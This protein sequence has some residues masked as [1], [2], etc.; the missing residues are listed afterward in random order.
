MSGG[1]SVYCSFRKSDFR[2]QFIGQFFVGS[3]AIPAVVQNRV[4]RKQEADP[5]RAIRPL[6]GGKFAP[7]NEF[8]GERE[9][10]HLDYHAYFQMGT[11]YTFVA[12]LLNMFAIFDAACGPMAYGNENSINGEEKSGEEV[13]W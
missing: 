10:W 5:Q 3:A 6:F 4:V 8:L 12:G 13:A 7:P 2:W 1:K 9:Q 11:L